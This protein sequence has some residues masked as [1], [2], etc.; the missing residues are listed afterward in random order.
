[1]MLTR[2]FN[3]LLLGCCWSGELPEQVG[4]RRLTLLDGNEEAQI[5]RMRELQQVPGVEYLD[6]SRG[7][8][9]GWYLP[10]NLI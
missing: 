3:N 2:G 5:V 7:I 10:M 8:A 9:S 4:R 6:A 1:M